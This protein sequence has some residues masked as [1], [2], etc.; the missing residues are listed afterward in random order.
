MIS[1][2]NDVVSLAAIDITRTNQYKFYSKILSEAEIPLYNEF[3][4]ARIPFEIFVWLLWSVKES[5]YKFLQRSE[6]RL[7]F[8]PVKFEVVNLRLPHNC[9][10][11]P[12]NYP[13]HEGKGFKEI[14][15]IQSTIKFAENTLHACSVLYNELI[16]TVANSGDDFNNLLWGVK[17]IGSDDSEA[18]SAEV[19]S[20][21]LERIKQEYGNNFR[22]EKN[23]NGCPVL[24]SDAADFPIPV[25]L[26]HHGCFVGYSFMKPG[27][28]DSDGLR[29]QST[30]SRE[31]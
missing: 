17:K 26:S 14:S 8:T 21:L 10:L 1:A 13:I 7:L 9:S 22:V 15:H 16:H 3:S 28:L 29:E 6:P 27:N 19:R 30:G 31:S 18:Q 2:G 20:F 24:L 23:N 25:S 12:F 11:S 5:A 4:L